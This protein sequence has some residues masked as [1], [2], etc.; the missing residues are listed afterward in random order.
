MGR[1]RWR[2]R[3]GGLGGRVVR[4]C[5]TF[6]GTKSRKMVSRR[7]EDGRR[8]LPYDPLVGRRKPSRRHQKVPASKREGEEANAGRAFR[9][10][11]GETS[12]TRFRLSGHALHRSCLPPR[13]PLLHQYIAGQ[14]DEWPRAP[15]LL[16]DGLPFRSDPVSHRATFVHRPSSSYSRPLGARAVRA[17]A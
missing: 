7:E 6:G 5:V 4:A 8:N 15:P 10:E 14:G 1:V 13:A 3:Q 9:K 17:V 16:A 2:E 11:R 12:S